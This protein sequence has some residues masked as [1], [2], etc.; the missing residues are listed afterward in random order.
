MPRLVSVKRSRS[1]LG[2]LALLV[3]LLLPG[4][5]VAD[6]LCASGTGSACCHDLKFLRFTNTYRSTWIPCCNQPYYA[7]RYRIDGSLAYNQRVINNWAFDNTSDAYRET[8]FAL[9]SS[10]TVQW[11]MKQFALGSC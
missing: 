2:L 5:A 11:D 10:S 7:R 8:A 9:D 4:A 3:V 1:T 6:T